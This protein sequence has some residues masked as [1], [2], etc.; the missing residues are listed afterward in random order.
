MGLERKITNDIKLAM[1]A[2]NREKLEV[3]RSI[4]SAII[5]SKTE[6][7]IGEISD[8]KGI[9]ILQKLLKQRQESEKI[10]LEQ[11]RQDLANKERIQANIISLYLPKPYSTSELESL[12]DSVML[13]NNIDSM[14]DM[15]KLISETLK[16]SQGR[17]TGKSISEIVKKKLS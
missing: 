11:G 10:F 2:K 15:G 3:C 7:G 16:I 4:K 12:V 1:L 5:L 13:D 14:V 8:Q 9:D 6:K 17:A